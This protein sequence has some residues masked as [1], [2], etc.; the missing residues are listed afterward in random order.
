MSKGQAR[1]GSTPGLPAEK[2]YNERRKTV[3][4]Y[5]VALHGIDSYTKEYMYLPYKFDAA[6]AETAIRRARMCAKA[7]YPRFQETKKPDVEVIRK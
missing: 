4:R 1:P 2:K 5:G 7:Y 3:E 6:S